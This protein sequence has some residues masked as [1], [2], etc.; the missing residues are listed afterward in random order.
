MCWNLSIKVACERMSNKTNY[1][2]YSFKCLWDWKHVYI[3][4]GGHVKWMIFVEQF[5][6]T[7][8]AFCKSLKCI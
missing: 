4:F 8:Q 5:E 6:T 7:Q 3:G 2:W 1:G